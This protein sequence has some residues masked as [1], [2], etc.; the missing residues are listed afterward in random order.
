MS[1]PNLPDILARLAAATPG[2]WHRMTVPGGDPI[3]GPTGE[4]RLTTCIGAAATVGA[5]TFIADANTGADAD[6]IAHAPADLAALAARVTELEADLATRRAY[7]AGC[8]SEV[9]AV[10][11]DRCC[12]TCGEDV[13]VVA[14]QMSLELVRDRVAD[15]KAESARLLQQLTEAKT[16]AADWALEACIVSG[17]DVPS[18]LGDWTGCWSGDF[19]KGFNGWQLTMGEY[20][21]T[22]QDPKDAQDSECMAEWKIWRITLEGP[23]EL[24]DQIDWGDRGMVVRAMRDAKAALDALTAATEATP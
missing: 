20:V 21:A 7:C 23:V 18:E 8:A 24:E 3:D 14:D 4:D 10:D 12:R 17:H 16:D 6:L 11:E 15:L 19:G 13:A 9:W 2:P 22:V 1:A 5:E